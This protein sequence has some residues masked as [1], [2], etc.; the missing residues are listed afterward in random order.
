MNNKMKS[1]REKANFTQKQMAEKLG[2]AVS[3]YNMMENGRR[4]IS[5]LTAKKTSLLLN[6]SIDKLFF[7]DC[8]HE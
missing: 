1:Y 2:I 6:T 7:N 5:L 8:V 4:G 3:T